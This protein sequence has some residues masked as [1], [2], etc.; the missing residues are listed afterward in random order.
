MPKPLIAH[1]WL[2]VESMPEQP[3]YIW[4]VLKMEANFLY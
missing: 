4:P 3:L 2:L 1:Q